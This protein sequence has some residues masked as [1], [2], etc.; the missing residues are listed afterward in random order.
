[1]L[2]ENLRNP[3][4][5]TRIVVFFDGGGLPDQTW[6]LPREFGFE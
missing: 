6:G 1:M 3:G 2:I 5:I 4:F